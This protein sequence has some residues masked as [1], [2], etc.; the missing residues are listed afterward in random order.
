MARQNQPN[1]QLLVLADSF[2]LLGDAIPIIVF[3]K[4]HIAPSSEHEV[5]STEQ[6]L[7]AYNTPA[8]ASTCVRQ[9]TELHDQAMLHV[10]H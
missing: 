4:A 6:D 10:S 5:I 7:H 1:I 2:Q 8:H 3:G 9:K